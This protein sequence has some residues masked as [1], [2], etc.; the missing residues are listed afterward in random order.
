MTKDEAIAKLDAFPKG[1][2]EE[3]A[4][5]KADEILIDFLTDNGH[6][7]LAAAFTRARARVGFWYA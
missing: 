2:D 4:H 7:E 3:I 6:E 5:S 1:D